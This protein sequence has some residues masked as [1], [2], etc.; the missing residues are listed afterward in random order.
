[1]STLPRTEQTKAGRS[2]A[3]VIG[4]AGGIALGMWLASAMTLMDRQAARPMDEQ[5]P[6]PPAITRGAVEPVAEL[7]DEPEP[8]RPRRVPARAEIKPAINEEAVTEARVTEAR[9]TEA[10]VIDAPIKA[11]PEAPKLVL[12][13][14]VTAPELHNRIK[15]VLARGTK[16]NLAVEGFSDAEQFATLAHAAR[17]TQVPFI[18][19]KHRVLTEHQSLSDAIRASKPDLDA[20]AEVQRA[21]NAAKSDLAALKP[22]AND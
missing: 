12:T 2:S 8:W 9:I 1:M 20:E 13:V 18:L 19:L 10:R 11:A 6:T 4:V 7:V 16:I 15:P 5:E 3:A 14:P 21:R 22:I 17:N